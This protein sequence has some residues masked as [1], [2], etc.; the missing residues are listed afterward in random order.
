[1]KNATV[2]MRMIDHSLKEVCL[3]IFFQN[4]HC[5]C[6]IIFVKRRCF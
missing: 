5:E 1:M 2:A 4:S 3:G 6:E